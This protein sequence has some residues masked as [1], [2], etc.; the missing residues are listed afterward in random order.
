MEAPLRTVNSLGSFLFAS[1][2][3]LSDTVPKPVVSVAPKWSG[4]RAAFY[5]YS[6]SCALDAEQFAMTEHPTISKDAITA[7]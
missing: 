3:P 2:L 5:E 1:F 7:D 6:Y 4:V